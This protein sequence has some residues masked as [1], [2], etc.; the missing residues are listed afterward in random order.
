MPLLAV[1]GERIDGSAA[2]RAMVRERGAPRQIV[3]NRSGRRFADEAAPYHD[4]G[5]A[6]QDH[7]GAV[8]VLDEGHRLRYG[9]PGAGAGRSV[10]D[11]V[12]SAGTLDGLAAALGVDPVGLA[13]QVGRWNDGCARGSDGEFGRGGTAYDRYYGDPARPGNPNLGPID[14]P[15]YYGIRVL[16]G[17]IGSKGGP[18]TD[19]DGRVLDRAGRPV[20]GLFAAGNAAAFWTADG[21]PGPGATLGIGMTIGFRAGRA[22]VAHRDP[23][24]SVQA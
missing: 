11:W 7:A 2:C 24:G 1:P 12:T 3:V 20:P 6:V 9:L 16:A 8:Q 5:R 17:T 19:P 22:I 21:C 18:V 15:P 10:P 4:F 14:R 13:D 23:E